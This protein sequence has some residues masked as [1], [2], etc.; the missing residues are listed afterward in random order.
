MLEGM[1]SRPSGD[2]KIRARDIFSSIDIN[3]DGTLTCEEFVKGGHIFTDISWSRLELWYSRLSNWRGVDEVTRQ[4]VWNIDGVSGK[5]ALCSNQAEDQI[6][7]II[8]LV[9]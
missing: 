4:D 5:P 3:H 2:P 9:I 6:F 7:E 8:N 1:G